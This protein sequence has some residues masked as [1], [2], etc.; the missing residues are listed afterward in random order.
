MDLGL[1]RH[2]SI[3]LVEQLVLGLERWLSSCKARP[4]S[5]LPSIRYLAKANDVSPSSVVEAYARL[6]A[7]GLLEARQGSGYFVS[8]ACAYAPARAEPVPAH[9]WGLFEPPAGQLGLGCGWL[10]DDWRDV[11]A[12]GHAIRRVTRQT[13][14]SLFGY[15]SPLG[16]PTLREHLLRRL[17]AMQVPADMQQI[18]TT[19]GASHALDLIVRGLLQP[20]DCVMV[21]AP[22]YYN[23]FNLLKLHHIRILPVPRLIDGPSPEAVAALLGQHRP[24]LMFINSLYQ[25]PTGTSLSPSV[26]HQLL[27]LA[28]A[29]D[30]MLI[31]DDI[32]A[33]FQNGP[34]TR[35]AALDGLRRVIY[36]TSFSKTLSSSLRVGYLAGP[37]P[38]IER[39]ADI[40]MC[41]GLGSQRFAEQVVADLLGS[42]AWLRAI[43]RLRQRLASHMAATLR[44]L[45]AHGWEVFVEPQGG[46]FVWVRLPGA[47]FAHYQATAAAHG[48]GLAP[49]AGFQPDGQATDWLRLNVAYINDARARDFLRDAARGLG[50]AIHQP[51]RHGLG[52]AGR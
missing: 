28:Q 45:A 22:G 2:A 17:T 10:P 34:S 44:L 29:H 3:P 32:Y 33:D 27:N 16:L 47:S 18:L 19:Q 12:M 36:L 11:E 51:L 25:N 49:G 6:V 20:G 26:A 7:Q 42:G 15:N 9:R 21:E 35:L 41:T 1:E 46:M 30:F 50:S 5:R 38:L 31:E 8:Q 23:L 40:A 48:V 14:S 37:A 4:G 39:L 24:K 43:G 52:H 13:P